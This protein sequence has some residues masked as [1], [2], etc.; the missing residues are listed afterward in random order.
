MH[1]HSAHGNQ[2]KFHGRLQPSRTARIPVVAA[3]T[4]IGN[5]CRNGFFRAVRK[6]QIGI[7]MAAT[8]RLIDAVL[9]L[10]LWKFKG[11]TVTPKKRFRKPRPKKEMWPSRVRSE[12]RRVGKECR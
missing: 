12:E 5:R 6:Q 9:R 2:S 1:P 11:P 8:I 7:V 10:P 4:G 3:T